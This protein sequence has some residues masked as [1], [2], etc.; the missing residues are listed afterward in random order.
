MVLKEALIETIGGIKI[1]SEL[2]A[3]SCFKLPTPCLYFTFTEGR[4]GDNIVHWRGQ[5]RGRGIKRGL[6]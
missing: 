6:D 5:N 2:S 4:G 1:T 3:E